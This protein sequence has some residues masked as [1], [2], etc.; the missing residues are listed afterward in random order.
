[1]KRK[2]RSHHQAAPTGGRRFR[3]KQKQENAI[4]R[5][6]DHVGDVVPGSVE[7]KKLTVNGV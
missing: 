6:K 4:Q 7:T 5:V 3:Q 2:D 1:V